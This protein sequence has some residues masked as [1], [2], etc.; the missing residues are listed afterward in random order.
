MGSLQVSDPSRPVRGVLIARDFST[1]VRLAAR[2][3]GIQLFSYGYNFTFTP[4]DGE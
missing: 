4:G 3:A 2:A 1:R